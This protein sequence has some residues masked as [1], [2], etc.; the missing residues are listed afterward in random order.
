[1][2]ILIH[3][4][5]A[6]QIG[7]AQSALSYIVKCLASKNHQIDLV[8][9]DSEVNSSDFSDLPFFSIAE[10]KSNDFKLFRRIH[11]FF[12]LFKKLRSLLKNKKYDFVIGFSSSA[13][14]RLF[15]ASLFTKS[16]LISCERSNFF[17]AGHSFVRR[18]LI[19]FCFSFSH[20][21]I[22][23]T[24]KLRD[25]MPFLVRRKSVVISNFSKV[26][27]VFDVNASLPKTY[28]IPSNKSIMLS[29]ARF[30]PEKNIHRLIYSFNNLSPIIKSNWILV[31]AGDGPLF[32]DCQKLVMDLN[33][34]DQIILLGFIPNPALLYHFSDLFVLS[35]DSE[36]MPN[37]LIEAL[38]YSLPIV[39][40]DC[41]FGPSEYVIHNFNGF[42][43]SASVSSLTFYIEEIISNNLLHD[44]RLNSKS[45]YT[46][47]NNVSL[48]KSWCS[49]IG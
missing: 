45:I 14:V 35:S 46:K 31:I 21:V 48:C 15:V 20:I 7:G 43:S 16:K 11:L 19:L 36:G 24:K 17:K 6:N 26:P 25:R 49:L 30:V 38:S 41:D 33:L 47:L 39:S 32:D 4:D 42:L 5:S 44:F 34:S 1:M 8:T 9:Y 28:G 12:N 13:S 3:I 29:V 10:H 37:V 40:V 27:I 22:F 23:Q 18:N 2:K